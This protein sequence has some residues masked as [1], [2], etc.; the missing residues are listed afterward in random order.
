MHQE[1]LGGLLMLAVRAV[2]EPGLGVTLLAMLDVRLANDTV[3]QPDFIITLADR[4]SIFR[5]WGL[6]G[7]PSLLAEIAWPPTDYRDRGIKR[8][9]YALYGVPEYW[10]IDPEHRRLTVFTDPHGD[11][12]RSQIVAND[13]A[14]SA[15]IPGLSVD[16]GVL[17]APIPVIGMSLETLLGEQHT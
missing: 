4:Y 13:V 12:Y 6:D 15:T 2:D 8:E 16:L 9:I 11:T 3:V 17:F 5:D 7:P 10:L 14:V 1:M